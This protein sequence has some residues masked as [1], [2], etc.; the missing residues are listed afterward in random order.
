MTILIKISFQITKSYILDLN[1]NQFQEETN[2]TEN[3]LFE[4]YIDILY[5]FR[6]SDNYL[7]I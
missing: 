5:E 3:V 4:N 7:F 1:Q 6:S 2:N